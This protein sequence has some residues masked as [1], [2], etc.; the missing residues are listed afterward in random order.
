MTLLKPASGFFNEKVIRKSNKLLKK[1]NRKIQFV[2]LR[3]IPFP[4]FAK[5]DKLDR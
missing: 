5:Y 3:T 1:E 4:N 2:F